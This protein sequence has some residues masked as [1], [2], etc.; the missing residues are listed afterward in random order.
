LGMF[1]LGFSYEGGT[2]SRK[3]LFHGDRL[4]NK[5]SAADAALSWL[6]DFLTGKWVPGL[7]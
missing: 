1:F 5:Q 6:R 2:Y 3:F 7:P 4:M